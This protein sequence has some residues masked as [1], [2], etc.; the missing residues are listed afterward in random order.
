MITFDSPQLMKEKYQFELLDEAK[1]YDFL[2]HCLGTEERA[3]KA[4]GGWNLNG[5]S[6]PEGLY[7]NI[8]CVISRVSDGALLVFVERLLIEVDSINKK[9]AIQQGGRV[10]PPE[11]RDR[12]ELTKDIANEGIYYFFVNCPLDVIEMTILMPPNISIEKR[13]P[14]GVGS[15]LDY[16]KNGTGYKRFVINKDKWLADTGNGNV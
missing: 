10:M 8:S 4:L 1:H 3:R 2:L 15:I 9:Y 11:V 14:Y 13:V 6:F 7:K 5:A 16:S 12:G